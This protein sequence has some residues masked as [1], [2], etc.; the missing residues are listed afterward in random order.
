M[1]C[2]NDDLIAI[3]YMSDS[4]APTSAVTPSMMPQ[5]EPPAAPEAPSLVLSA[6]HKQKKTA[7]E[8]LAPHEAA[9]L[10]TS[11]PLH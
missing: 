2:N 10:P 3:I 4:S 7:L 11:T 9:L 8:R 1:Q 6:H 5:S